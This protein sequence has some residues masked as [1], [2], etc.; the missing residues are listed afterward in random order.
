MNGRQAE[1]SQKGIEILKLYIHIYILSYPC[2][3][4]RENQPLTRLVLECEV[5]ER[6]EV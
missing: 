5:M 2:L 3:Y 6:K 4:S 1:D